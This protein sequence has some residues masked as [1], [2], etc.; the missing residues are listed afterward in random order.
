MAR[1]TN[2]ATRDALAA[3][4]CLKDDRLNG[5]AFAR[6]LATELEAQHVAAGLEDVEA[7]EITVGQV[8]GTVAGVT[9]EELVDIARPLL[10]VGADGPVQKALANG[11]VLIGRRA[12][13][14]VAMDGERRSVSVGTRFLSSDVD[15]L[16]KYALD[17]IRAKAIAFG[18]RT[19]ALG[20]L[21]TER[22][23]LMAERS[24]TFI[25]QLKVT[26][27]KALSQ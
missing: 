11:Y 24:D 22:Q 12:K 1:F 19:A 20:A 27:T 6:L 23:P 15:V 14:D 7:V 9:D 5:R 21:I 13:I 3:L 16:E 8:I 2:P 26:F 25:K 17:P 4:D 18:N 10:A